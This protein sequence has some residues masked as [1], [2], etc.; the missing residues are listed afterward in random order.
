ME[1]EQAFRWWN[2]SNWSFVARLTL[3]IILLVAITLA[4]VTYITTN[5]VRDR[6]V[7]QAGQNFRAQ[8]DSLNDSIGAFFLERVGQLQVQSLSKVMAQILIDRNDSYQGSEL[9]IFEEIQLLDA[10]WHE[11]PDQ[12]E[13]VS[14]V[15]S[16]NR[17]ENPVAFRLDDFQDKFS[18]YQRVLVTDRYGALVAATERPGNYYQANEEWWR[19]AWN[20]GQGAV[21]ISAPYFD[22]ELEADVLEM[23]VPIRD[24][25]ARTMGV[26]YSVLLADDLFNLIGKRVQIGDTGHAIL[27]NNDGQVIY[28]PRVATGRDPLSELPDDPRQ[29]YLGQEAGFE[30]SPDTG[31]SESL[32]GYASRRQEDFPLAITTPYEGEIIEAVDRLDWKILVRQEASE[33][34]A[35]V[36]T[37]ARSSFLTG[38][39][40]VLLAGLVAVVVSRTVTRPLVTLGKAAEEMGSGNL[41]VKLPPAG[42]DE[43]GRLT[44]SFGQMAAQLRQLVDSL[45]ERVA[46]RTRRL[47]LVAAISERLSAILE[48]DKLLNEIVDQ[49]QL[50]FG[51]YHA[52]IYLLDEAQERLVVAA[53]TGQAGKIMKARGHNIRLDALTS[54]VAR[55]ARSHE[56]VRVDNVRQAKDWLPNPLLPDTYSEMAVPIVLDEEVVGVL[57]VQEDKIGGLDEGD[58]SLL[59][60]LANQVAVAIRNANLFEE[61]ERNLEEAHELQRR[62]MEQAW[63]RS[64]VAERARGRAQ[65]SRG[66]VPETLSRAAVERARQEALAQDGPAFI[67]VDDSGRRTRGTGPLG[68]GNGRPDASLALVAPIVL[69]GMPIGNLQL[70]N[71]DPNREW[72]EGELALVRSVVDQVAQVAEGLRLLDETQEQASQ[73]RLVGRVTEKMRRAADMEALMQT[74]VDELAEVLGPTRAFVRLDSEAALK[75]EAAADEDSDGRSQSNDRRK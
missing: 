56:V 30:V 48:L 61:V 47:E 74:L 28:D 19:V 37:I 44:T 15:L 38:V 68:G 62:Y 71:I 36:N 20:D 2:P 52:H 65:Y 55:A 4:A 11:A 18:E 7:A 40:A 13:L 75:A 59:R 46:G 63:D 25:Q 41:S 1:Q 58:V 64:R 54:L 34:F 23:A 72:T 35:S 24:E 39:G 17:F 10:A 22:R 70:H 26:L 43:I 50:N 33:A 60:S 66:T 42:Q 32:F 45:E 6:L 5:I 8:A 12:S 57:D 31:G 69:R 21:Y 67:W 27:L 53:G 14:Q 73:E 9:D 3:L 51:Y 29:T 16:T 49:I